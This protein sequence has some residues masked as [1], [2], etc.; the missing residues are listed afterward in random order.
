MSMVLTI[1]IIYSSKKVPLNKQSLLPS[2]FVVVSGVEAVF[3]EAGRS[4]HDLLS[5]EGSVR[6]SLWNPPI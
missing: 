4:Q 6:V 5:G 3:L 1:I 2:A